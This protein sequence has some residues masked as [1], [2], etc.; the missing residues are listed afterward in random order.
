MNASAQCPHPTLGLDAQLT[1]MSDSNVRCLQLMVKC[2]ACQCQMIF[3][4]APLGVSLNRPTMSIDGSM[5]YIPVFPEGEERPAN[6]PEMIAR[7]VV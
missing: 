2:Q 3:I 7:R 6:L 1:A 4:G 5:L